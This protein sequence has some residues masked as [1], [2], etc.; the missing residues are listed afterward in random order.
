MFLKLPRGISFN[1]C[2]S[3]PYSVHLNNFLKEQKS[4][5]M[6]KN[7][8]GESL[9]KSR[10]STNEGYLIVETS[11]RIEDENWS[12][13]KTIASFIPHSDETIPKVF[14][15]PIPLGKFPPHS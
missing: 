8:I 4:L 10:I 2:V 11:D 7:K 15:H 6:M 5:R 1:L 3:D 9:V 13:Y 14:P 12:N